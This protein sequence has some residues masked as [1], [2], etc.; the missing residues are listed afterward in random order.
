VP[1]ANMKASRLKL[2]SDFNRFFMGTIEQK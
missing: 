1:Q 2:A